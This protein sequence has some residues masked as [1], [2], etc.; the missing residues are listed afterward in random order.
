MDRD[1]FL[2]VDL[3]VL[4]L[5]GLATKEVQGAQNQVALVRDEGGEGGGELVLCGGGGEGFEEQGV[6]KGDGLEE[7]GQLVV[8][9]FAAADDAEEEVHLGG[10]EELQVEVALFSSGFEGGRGGAGSGESCGGRGREGGRGRGASKPVERSEGSGGA[11]EKE[12][13]KGRA[14]E[15]EARQRW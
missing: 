7:G 15:K 14:G 1:A 11:G 10:R 3:E 8:A 5:A 4:R 2:E 13:E 9:V 6:P 12:E